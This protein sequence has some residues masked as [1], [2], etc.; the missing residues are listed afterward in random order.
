MESY[1]GTIVAVV[2][3]YM[4]LTPA[5]IPSINTTTNRTPLTIAFP[6]QPSTGEIATNN[7]APTTELPSKLPT[8]EIVTDVT[9]NPALNTDFPSNPPTGELLSFFGRLLEAVCL[10]GPACYLCQLILFLIFAGPFFIL[11]VME[12]FDPL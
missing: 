11:C 4:I 6:L 8:E 7:S 2:I 12:L 10:P 9:N 5:V 3:V 1:L